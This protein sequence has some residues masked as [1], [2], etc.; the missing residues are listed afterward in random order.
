MF[1]TAQFVADLRVALRESQ[2]SLAVRELVERAVADRHALERALGT[3]SRA[4]LAVLHADADVTVLH[5]VWAPHMSLLPHDHN[6]T[7]VIGL[8]NGRED[9]TFWRR[10]EPGIE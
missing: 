6:M 8:Y 3:P 4:D 5:A 1:E 9:N 10:S 7:A 2:P